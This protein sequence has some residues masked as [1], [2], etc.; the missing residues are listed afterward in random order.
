[1]IRNKSQITHAVLFLI[2]LFE[3][4]NTFRLTVIW[5]SPRRKPRPWSPTARPWPRMT[6]AKL[7]SRIQRFRRPHAIFRRSHASFRRWHASFRPSLII[8]DFSWH[9]MRTFSCEDDEY[10]FCKWFKI[11]M[12]H[13]SRA[14]GI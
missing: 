7:Q 6:T 1:M 3:N 12:A 8:A 4:V 13:I 10:V 14:M 2:V 11:C 5:R 9:F